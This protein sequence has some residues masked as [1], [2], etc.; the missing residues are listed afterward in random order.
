MASAIKR[1]LEKLSQF[2][3][4]LNQK[5][6]DKKKDGTKKSVE[7]LALLVRDTAYSSDQGVFC[8]IIYGRDRAK[9][10]RLGRK[11]AAEWKQNIVLST[12]D[13]DDLFI[14]V[15]RKKPG[16]PLKKF[17]GQIRLAQ[18]QLNDAPNGKIKAWY[19]LQGRGKK[20]DLVAGKIFVNLL[21]PNSQNQQPAI[22]SRPHSVEERPLLRR[23]KPDVNG[24][25]DRIHE[26]KP[27]THQAVVF[28]ET[29]LDEF[30]MRTT[31]IER[32]IKNV[33]AQTR[34]LETKLSLLE[35]RGNNAFLS[36]EI[37]R[38]AKEIEEE[39]EVGM[40]KLK[41]VGSD[42]NATNDKDLKAK[43]D[44]FNSILAHLIQRTEHFNQVNQ[45]I[46]RTVP[47]VN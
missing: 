46:R 25:V 32:L 11:E 35:K 12:L 37:E 23:A 8:R 22:P 20:R 21:I 45:Q 41:D 30:G 31:A 33:D 39:I 40:K 18:K 10:A 3:N 36:N 47:L 15:W 1:V 19:P 6:F 26:L 27:E 7:I 43:M 14:Q 17:L 44:H 34:A 2:R 42:L 29:R 9:T 28:N 13:S 4:S 38:L 24:V 5:L 16:N